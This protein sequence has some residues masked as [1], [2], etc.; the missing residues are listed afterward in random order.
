M[1]QRLLFFVLLSFALF[2]CAVTSKVSTA[3]TY[4]ADDFSP[5]RINERGMAILPITAGA[6]L[7][8]YRRPFGD[9]LNTS[10]DGLFEGVVG[11]N[12]TM[13]ILNQA[14]LVSEYQAA[15]QAYNETAIL[16]QSV[17]RKMTEAL[18]VQYL[19]YV[20]LSPPESTSQARYN[21]LAGTAYTEQTQA[22]FAYAKIW[23]RGGDVVWEGSSEAKAVS[24]A[25]S[26]IDESIA[27]QCNKTAKG[28]ARRL[29]G[30]AVAE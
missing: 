28:L 17:M 12:K 10:V 11:W 15:I 6:D 27:E 26:Y 29:R 24:G 19:L 9:E 16:D 5:E 23:D 21:A 25:Y 30:L 13:E 22:V 1:V 8:G 14:D 3:E 18:D 7:E 20:R 2:S 4:R